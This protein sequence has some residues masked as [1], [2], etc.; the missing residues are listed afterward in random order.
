MDRAPILVH[1][2]SP[3]GG[4]R[5]VIRVRGVD[6]VLGVA[7]SDRDLIEFL[8]RID[9]PDPDE[10]VLGDSEVIAWQGGRPHVYEDSEEPPPEDGG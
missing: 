5:V 7:Y 6:T 8:R 9:I 1:R 10:L 2:I 3:S 4:R